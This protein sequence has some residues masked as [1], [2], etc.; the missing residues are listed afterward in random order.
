MTI[1][2]ATT[3]REIVANDFRTAAVFQR[4]GLD[5]CCNGSRTVQQGCRDAGADELAL[6]RELGHVM[7][8][9][10]GATPRFATWEPAALVSY[11]VANHHAFVRQAI[12]PLLQHTRKI[13]EV[14]GDRHTELPHIAR[15]FARVADEMRDHMMKEEQVLFPFILSLA[16]AAQTGRPAPQPPFGSVANPIRTMEHEHR[17]VGD[18]MAE[19]RSLTDGFRAPG[20]A[21]ATYRVCLQ[22]LE[23][24][25][26]DL[27]AH[28]HLENNI[29]FPK[30]VELESGARV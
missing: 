7:T 17:F 16:D 28:V 23:A 13:A 15:L 24:F 30:A 22:E 18:A 19:I 8:A 20:N 25:E 6:I 27:H 10:A 2:P 4:F 9:P 3:I 5:F 1:S 11:I 12:P 21:C 26:A 29:L 14:H